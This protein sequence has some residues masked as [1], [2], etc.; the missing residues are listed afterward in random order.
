MMFV[1]LDT[2]SHYFTYSRAPEKWVLIKKVSIEN[3][4]PIGN[5]VILSS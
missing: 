1:T 2:F 5:N 4:S 3:Y